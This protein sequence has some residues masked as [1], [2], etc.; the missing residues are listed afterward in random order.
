MKGMIGQFFFEFGI[1]VAVAVLLSLF[2]SFTL[3]PMLSSRFLRPHEGEPKGLS[4]TIERGLKAL[5]SGYRRL[6]RW[7][8]GHRASTVGIAIGALILTMAASSML[9]FEFLPIQDTGQFN[10]TLEA[11]PGTSLDE[12]AR[13]STELAKRIRDEVPGVATTFT[14]IGGGAQERVNFATILVTLVPRKERDY[15]QTE[16]MAYIRTL[17]EGSARDK[18]TVAQ[19]DRAGRGGGGRVS[20]LQ[21]QI[22]GHDLDEMQAVAERMADDLGARPGFADV[23]TSFRA[24][25]P[26]L[27]VVLDRNRAADLGISGQQVAM[28]VRTLLA[29]Q[30]ATQIQGEVDRYDIRVQLPESNRNSAEVIERAYVRAPSGELISI[31]SV[32]TVRA[33]VGPSKID[34]EARQRQISIFANLD[35]KALGDAVN[36]TRALAEVEIGTDMGFTFG[37]DAQMFEESM[38]SMLFAL[39]LA[40]VCV[41]MI[42]AAQFESFVHPFT[43]MMSLPFSL[44][45]AFGSLLLVG[46]NMSI[47]GMIG[48]IM[49]MGLVT[50]NAIL[51]VEFAN[52]RRAQGDS[53]A[54]AMENAGAIRLRPILMTTAAMIFGMLPVAIGHGD[55]GE[56]RSPMGVTVIGGLITSTVLTLIVVPVI[57]TLVDDV[58]RL[59]LRLGRR[60][61][62]EP[63]QSTA[64]GAVSG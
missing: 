12:T 57:Y 33:N 37:G 59:A 28:T 23:D 15:H 11:P 29:G 25:K 38:E 22:H 4:A 55:G 21:L 42:L 46:L 47:F 36:E 24:G 50:K 45:G 6:I 48:L 40:I 35:G 54:E 1:T 39:F 53:I 2:V 43:I 52:Q 19:L 20:P 8:L 51:I 34:R 58:S 60:R 61:G 63:D 27:E 64:K 17:L 18:T 7:A 31:D 9:G 16:A 10:V 41:Y 56:L 13:R 30:V 5:D 26:E 3:T 14:T 49:L 44:I 32:A 62:A